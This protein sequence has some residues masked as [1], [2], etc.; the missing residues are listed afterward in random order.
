M[1]ERDRR[2]AD[3]GV[4]LQRFLMRARLVPPVILTIALLAGSLAAEAQQTG[5]VFRVGFLAAFS[6]SA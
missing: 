3:H 2:A 1:P 4:E 5:K 6:A